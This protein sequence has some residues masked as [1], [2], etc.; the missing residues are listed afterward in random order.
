M[1][2]NPNYGAMPME[3]YQPTTSGDRAM[4]H[5]Y[6]NG[7]EQRHSLGVELE[8]NGKELAELAERI[9]ELESRLEPVLQSSAP[10]PGQV[11]GDSIKPVPVP[12]SQHMARAIALRQ[13][14][15]G[16][17]LKVADIIRRLDV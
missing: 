6:G 15:A 7:P 9:H 2:V 11:Q 13:N 8:I 1:G 4:G 3:A 12:L 16:L 10:I 17:C 14:V 5:G